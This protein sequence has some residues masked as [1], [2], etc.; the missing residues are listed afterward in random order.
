MRIVFMGTPDFAV[1]CLEQLLADG[2][3]VV[4]AVTQPD[5][6]KGRG[7]QLAP[8]PVK[9][10]ALTK[11]V[12]VYQPLSL[13]T[14]EAYEE[15]AR[16]APELIVVVAYGKLLPQ[17]VLD[18]PPL[19]CINVHA[20]LLPRFRGA[21][22]IQWAILKGDTEAGVTT[23]RME[24]GLDTGDMLLKSR[25]PL[26][27]NMTSGELHD[28]LALDGAAL[29]SET[30]KALEAGTLQPEKQQEAAS[31]YAPMLD[32]S[33]CPLDWSKPAAVLHNQV[34]GLNPW[35][36]AVCCFGGRS[37]KVH[38]SRIGETCTEEPGIVVKGNPLTVSCGEGS[39]LELLEVQAE[40]ARRM[41]SADYVR[42]HPVQVGVRLEEQ[43]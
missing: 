20:S 33:L 28:L 17:R 11:G 38:V 19:G 18:L 36:T 3:E 15:L 6:P 34:R 43:V 10:Y 21:A 40:G 4:L 31:C 22:P 8:P 32:K 7:H 41:A 2:H 26:P 23:M 42:G 30:L 29:L 35:P 12:A 24:A 14:D 13:K 9:A 27:E 25:R 5:K 1:P 16:Y 37:L 39:T